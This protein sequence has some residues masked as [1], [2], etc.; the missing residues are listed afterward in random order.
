MSNLSKN[1]LTNIINKKLDIILMPISITRF[2]AQ[3]AVL[4]L[5]KLG[6]KV[7]I[8]HLINLKPFE[9]K[10]NWINAIKTSKYGV[11]M[12]DNDYNDG[13]LRTIAHKINEKTDKKIHVMGLE[14]KS[15]G[16]HYKVDN[17]PPD[18]SKIIKKVLKITK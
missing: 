16:H 13:V 6:L 15:A 3:K 8:I 9:L 17:I 18:T 1:F 14:H 10:K 7:G 4:Q 11:L 5:N 2:A 12:T